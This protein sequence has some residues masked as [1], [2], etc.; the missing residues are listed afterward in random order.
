MNPLAGLIGDS[1]GV[2]ALREQI[3][4]LLAR[5]AR[6]PRWP[7]LLVLGETGVGRGISS[8]RSIKEGR[9]GAARSST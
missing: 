5:L 3:V 8:A 2:G 1:L 4:R 6:M 7:S 9:A